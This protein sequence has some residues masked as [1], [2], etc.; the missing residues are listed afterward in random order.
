MRGGGGGGKRTRTN[1]KVVETVPE[2][3]GRS[4]HL[5]SDVDFLEVRGLNGTGIVSS[6]LGASKDGADGA[7]FTCC[8][9][10]RGHITRSR[11]ELSLSNVVRH[12]IQ[13]R[14]RRCRRGRG[15]GGGGGFRIIRADLGRTLVAGIDRRVF[16]R[17][18]KYE[19]GPANNATMSQR[20]G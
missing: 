14:S 10:A 18:H 9:A 7:E 17:V 1:R 2:T 8:M 16:S 3:S 12:I 11:R 19:N 15:G 5:S 6:R 20:S 4:Y 13:G